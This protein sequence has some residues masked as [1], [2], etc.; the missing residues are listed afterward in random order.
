MTYQN[1]RERLK[2]K[3]RAAMMERESPRQQLECTCQWV[4]E[5]IAGTGQ[6][7][8]NAD[9]NT[10]MVGVHHILNGSHGST[11]EVVINC[12]KAYGSDI[13]FL[14]VSATVPNVDDVAS[15]IG[16]TRNGSAKIF[17]VMPLRFAT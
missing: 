5:I 2:G 8:G 11:L 9:T 6:P 10:G 3:I 7:N 17:E 14:L 1:D 12:M 16:G 4:I 15:W 13:H